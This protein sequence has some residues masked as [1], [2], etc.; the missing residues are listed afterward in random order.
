MIM[1]KC[2]KAKRNPYLF[3]SVSAVRVVATFTPAVR[4]FFSVM[5]GVGF[6]H[7]GQR[8]EASPYFISNLSFQSCFFF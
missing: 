5:G 7:I 8:K 4:F 6:G 2:Q 3:S 1:V